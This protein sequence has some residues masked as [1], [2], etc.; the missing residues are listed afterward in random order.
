MTI[1]R[2]RSSTNSTSHN[3]AAGTAAIIQLYYTVEGVYIHIS[4]LHLSHCLFWVYLATFVVRFALITGVQWD[5][6]WYIPWL[7]KQ[8]RLTLATKSI[9]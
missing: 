6:C 9:V 7:L 5:V 4:K 8:I 2:D 1:F 3:T